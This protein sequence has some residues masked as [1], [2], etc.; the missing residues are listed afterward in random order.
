M[1]L[2]DFYKRPF[3]VGQTVM[4]TPPG[5]LL[6]GQ[7]V[8]VSDLVTPSRNNPKVQVRRITVTSTHYFEVPLD[9]PPMLPLAIVL[10]P[11]ESE[12]GDH[13]VENKPKLIKQ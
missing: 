8:E 11:E 9:H 3:K 4:F 12:A 6:D 7:V 13:Y 2:F 1:A 5:P 10:Q